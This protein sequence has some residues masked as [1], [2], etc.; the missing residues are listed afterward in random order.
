MFNPNFYQK[1]FSLAVARLCNI[2]SIMN[3]VTYLFIMKK[4]Q[5]IS[6]NGCH[7]HLEPQF[8]IY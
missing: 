3:T 1:V 6:G 4:E 8:P 5:A 7:S 2:H